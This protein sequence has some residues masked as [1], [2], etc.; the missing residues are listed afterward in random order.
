MLKR[1]VAVVAALVDVGGPQVPRGG[2]ASTKLCRAGRKAAVMA[3]VVIAVGA[4]G[5]NSQGGLSPLRQSSHPMPSSGAGWKDFVRP[6]STSGCPSGP[7]SDILAQVRKGATTIT[8]PADVTPSIEDAAKDLR[9][10]EGGNCSQLPVAGLDRAY[11][12]C[13]FD[14][15]APPTAPVIIVIGDSRAAMWSLAFSKLASQLGY[16]FGLVYR[17]G[18]SMPRVEHPAG[19]GTSEEECKAWKDAAIN[20]V[21]Q[22]NPAVVL[23]ASGPDLPDVGVTP[24]LLTT[25]YAATLKELQAPARKLFVLGEVPHLQQNP[26][27]CLAA[28]LSSA[29]ACATPTSSATS[30]DE[31]QADLHAAQQAGAGYVNLTPW[32][33][34]E[35]L[36]PA[37]VGNY[38]PY[39]DQLHLNQTFTEALIPV[40]QQAIK[41]G[42]WPR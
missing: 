9:V 41:I 3:A 12:P 28:H 37:I 7:C 19:G 29:K 18:C 2:V 4:C 33:C 31:Q 8:V 36:C 27:A 15:G 40:L 23:V 13:V 6:S 21:N 25:G 20:W 34:T 10:P 38:L 14:A 35:D 17:A 1:L 24:A 42:A 39:L 16:R 30:A 26:P 32:L 11:Q 22:Q 5:D